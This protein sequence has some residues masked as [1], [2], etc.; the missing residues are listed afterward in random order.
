MG[1][2]EAALHRHIGSWPR[3]KILFGSPM[4]DGAVLRR[5][6]GA[7]V[8]CSDQVI[9]GVHV[10]PDLEPRRVGA[11]AALRVLSDLA[12]CAAWPVALECSL[13]VPRER[14]PAWLRGVLSGVRSAARR[15]GAELVGGDLAAAP[16]PFGL[17][18][19]ALG[20]FRG[21]GRP[22]GRDRLRVG[23]TLLLT[24]PVGGSLLGRHLNIK[25]RLAAGR[26][27]F[28]GGARALMDVSDGLA[29]DLGRLAARSGL[30]IVLEHVPIHAQARQRARLTGRSALEHALTDGEDHE[31]LAG[32][33]PNQAQALLDLGLPEC[34]RATAIGR[35]IARPGLWLALDGAEPR[36]YLGAGGFLHGAES[37]DQDR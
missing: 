13:R 28:A 37:P 24:G 25:P 32:L 6:R 27:L 23:D 29:L 14:Q 15:H 10:L 26:A 5:V 31:L 18:V 30:G 3:P 1:W 21:P 16:G 4:S 33:R 2:N 7:P 17:S 12:A 8:L 22:P 35:V 34:P 19:T 20:E 36:R 11:K 9:E